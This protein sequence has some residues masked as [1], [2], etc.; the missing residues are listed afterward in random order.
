ML[1]IKASWIIACD[2]PE[3]LSHFYGLALHAS[4]QKGINNQHWTVTSSDFLRIQFYRFS[5]KTPSL[6]GGRRSSLCLEKGPLKDPLVVIQ[7]WTV[8]LISYGAVSKEPPKILSFGVESWLK[9]PEGNDF[10][11]FAQIDNGI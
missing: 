3:K 9:D 8:E 1:K 2:D 6:I 5:K 10:L 4:P 11:I 7:Q